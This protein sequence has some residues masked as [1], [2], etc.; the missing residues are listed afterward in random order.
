MYVTMFSFNIEV[1]GLMMI[2]FQ[3]KEAIFVLA[4]QL[5]ILR[6]VARCWIF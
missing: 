6:K 5:K 3:V 2:F 4:L 1:S